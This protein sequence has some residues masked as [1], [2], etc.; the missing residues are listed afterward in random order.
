VVVPMIVVVMGVTGC[1]KITI[2]RF[3]AERLGVAYAEVDSFHPPANVVK[4]T[5]GQALDDEGTG[6]RGWWGSWTGSGLA[7]AR[8]RAM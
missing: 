4:M 3:L 7:C 8:G 6:I 1:G 2:G 5:A